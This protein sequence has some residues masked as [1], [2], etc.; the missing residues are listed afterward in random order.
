M[1]GH[2]RQQARLED[3]TALEKNIIEFIGVQSPTSTKTHQLAVFYHETFAG[4]ASAHF[5]LTS[6]LKKALDPLVEALTLSFALNEII[7][8]RYVS[9]VYFAGDIHHRECTRHEVES[10]L[11][12]FT[13]N[14]QFTLKKMSVLRQQLPEFTTDID[15][16]IHEVKGDVD[17]LILRLQQLIA[18]THIA[19][20]KDTFHFTEDQA[21]RLYHLAT[22]RYL[23]DASS[24]PHIATELA[25]LTQSLIQIINYTP[26]EAI[27]MI[28][29]VYQQ[30]AVNL[31]N[32]HNVLIALAK[33]YQ[34]ALG[35]SLKIVFSHLVTQLALVQNTTVLTQLITK[36]L[37]TQL[38]LKTQA[39]STALEGCHVLTTFGLF[40][41]K[42]NNGYAL[43]P[44][45]SPACYSAPRS[46]LA[47]AFYAAHQ[48]PNKK[49]AAAEPVSTFRSF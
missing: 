40:R 5:F 15:I 37:E 22:S 7:A 18:T 29:S 23:N 45:K 28:A 42:Q 36:E 11:R 16:L 48:N 14:Y 12:R 35:G 10:H 1:R 32:T 19:T 34:H 26:N 21:T 30:H 38:I 41:T 27:E 20:L 17:Q 24:I 47:L 44:E 31:S 33:T 49:R 4:Y 46:F 9:T 39:T 13:E 2:R 6:C 43:N 3:F 8:A 25:T